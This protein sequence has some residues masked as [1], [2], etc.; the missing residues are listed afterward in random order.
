MKIQRI[1]SF[2]IIL[3]LASA[4]VFAQTPGNPPAEKK[5]Q[6]PAAQ[7]PSSE[8]APGNC[9]TDSPRADAYYN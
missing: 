8:A 6:T 3:G 9:E 7:S 4:P 2:A 1:V 5:I